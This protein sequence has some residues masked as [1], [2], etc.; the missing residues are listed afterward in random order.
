[1]VNN[2]KKTE[3]PSIKTT[4]TIN[5]KK[6]ASV[7]DSGDLI[8]QDKVCY[9]NLE[10][11]RKYTAYASLA[12]ADGKTV[13]DVIA[14]GAAVN[15]TPASKNGCVSVE[16][17]I[18]KDKIKTSTNLTVYEQVKLD[19]TII[20]RHGDNYSPWDTD[21]DAFIHDEI[22]CRSKHRNWC[23]RKQYSAFDFTALKWNRTGT[24]SSQKA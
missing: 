10:V 11:G 21:S 4:A 23:S 1:M 19:G 13:A 20:A 2:T 12:D 18:N 9:T 17:K 5:G 8:I 24:A 15:F 6:E 16:L 14:S 7:N 3:A 22:Q